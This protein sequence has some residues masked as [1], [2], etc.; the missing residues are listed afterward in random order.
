MNGPIQNQPVIFVPA[1]VL[2]HTVLNLAMVCT[3]M[4]LR[5]LLSDQAE[6]APVSIAEMEVYTGKSASSLYDHLVVLRRMGLVRQYYQAPG[7]L[8]LSF[9]AE[10]SSEKLESTPKNRNPVQK[11]GISP[12]L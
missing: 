1:Q 8:V 10:Y 11:T 12:S 6:S 9:P 4:Q 5:L 3:W 7:R 2:G